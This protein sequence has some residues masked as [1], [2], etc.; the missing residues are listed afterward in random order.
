MLK[1]PQIKDEIIVKFTQNLAIVREQIIQIFEV[2]NIDN[3]PFK[4]KR[5][6]YS[7]KLLL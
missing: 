5:I 6:V 3:E 7:R 4:G 2:G 1:I